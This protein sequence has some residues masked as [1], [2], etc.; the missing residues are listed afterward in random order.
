MNCTTRPTS[1]KAEFAITRVSVLDQISKL[2]LSLLFLKFL[3]PF[4][5]HKPHHIEIIMMKIPNNLLRLFSSMSD[6]WFT[7]KS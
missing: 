1:E 7:V 4:F 6:I 5:S 3:S 2:L